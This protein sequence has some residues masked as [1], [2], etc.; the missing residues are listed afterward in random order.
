MKKINFVLLSLIIFSTSSLFASNSKW[1][2]I[3]KEY[4]DISQ[5]LINEN[6]IFVSIDDTYMQIKSIAQDQNGFYFTKVLTDQDIKW[7]WTCDR[8]G[9]E[10]SPFRINCKNCGKRWS[11]KN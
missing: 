1:Q 10:N 11:E 7:N 2:K 8:C 4:I 9:T 6:G 5:L 3:N